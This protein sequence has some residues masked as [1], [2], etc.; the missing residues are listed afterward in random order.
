MGVFV[1]LVMP[2]GLKNVPPTYQR[3]VNMAFKEYLGVFVKL[4]LDDFSV[5]SDLKTH[6]A[7]LLLC[8]S[9]CQEFDIS[10]NL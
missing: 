3:V 1:W 4:F 8:F 5:F 9:K 6:P 7:K 10:F 2:F